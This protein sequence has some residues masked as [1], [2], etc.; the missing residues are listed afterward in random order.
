MRIAMTRS[1]SPAGVEPRVD[2]EASALAKAGHDVHVLL[3]DRKGEHAEEES[4]NGYTIHRCRVPA[5]EGQFGLL[6][7][8][9]RWWLW[10]FSTL[11]RLRPDVAHSCDFDTAPPALAYARFRRKKLV[12]D[13]FDF[14]AYMIAQPLGKA[15][16]NWL[17]RMERFVARKADLVIVADKA[18]VVQLG[19]GFPGK[20]LEILNV[21]KETSVVESEEKDFTVFYGGML[22]WERGLT[23][24]V[25][26]TAMAGVKLVV[27]GHGADEATLVPLFQRSPHVTFLGNITYQEVL[28]WTARSH[29]IA[30]LYDPVIPNNR[31]AAPNKLYE[32]MMLSRP[33]VTNEETRPAEIIRE[34]GCG[35]VVKYGE[36]KGLADSL[37]EIAANAAMR[38]EMGA[39]GRRAFEDRFN[40]A[41]MERRLAEAYSA[42]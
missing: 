8:M 5:P 11:R 2:R 34:V 26:A 27:A 29:V 3:W 12:Y 25:E 7:R 33:V 41:T 31:L 13:I 36:I 30:A 4:L 40:W 38:K 28:R 14:Y 20:V 35:V 15:T 18:R 10:E 22:S 37:K 39:K 23:Q 21:P 17:A 1:K 42:L 6:P 24:L 16:R 32:A 9:G 19:Q